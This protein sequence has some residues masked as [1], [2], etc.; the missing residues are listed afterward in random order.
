MLRLLKKSWWAIL[1]A[2]GVQSASGFTLLGLREPYQVLSL[3]Y[4]GDFSDQPK[5]FD[6]G[7]RWTIPTAYYTFDA[8][9]MSYFGSNGVWS[10]EQGIGILNALTNVSSYSP[11]L[12]EFP[13]ES[14]RVNWTAQA[15]GLFDLKS[16]T[17]EV[18]LEELG[19]GD[20]ERFAWTLRS[21][22]LPGGAQCPNYLYAV[23]QRNFDPITIAPSP[24]V[25]GNLFSYVIVDGCP[26]VDQ[27]DALE[28]PVDPTAVVA[29]AVASG[30]FMFADSFYW[31]YYYTGLTR[32]D[33]GGLRWLYRTN[34]LITSQAGGTTITFTTNNTAPQL[35]FTSNLTLF[36][37]QALTNAA[38]PLQ[39]LYPDLV[40]LST[41]NTFANV[42]T[43]NQIPYFT[44][45]PMDPVGTAPHV[46]FSYTRTLTIQPLYFHTFGN[47]YTVTNVAGG[48][49]AVPVGSLPAQNGKRIVT[50][51]TTTT[52]N[53]PYSP[54]VSGTNGTI[55][56]LTNTTFKTYATNGVVGEYFIVPTNACAVNILGLQ[57]SFTNQTTNILFN[58]TNNITNP[59][60]NNPIST[61]VF[62][63]E[64][65]M[66]NYSTNHA[67]VVAPVNCD[68][69]SVALR[70]GIEKVT[71]V[72]RDYDSLLNRFFYP[73]TNIYTLYAYTNNQIIPQRVQRIVTA[74]DILF[75]A[76]DI[77][78][79]GAPLIHTTV[80]RQVPN[81]T[82]ATNAVVAGAL[83]GP[84]TIEPSATFTF[85]KV[86]P[87]YINLGPGSEVDKQLTYIWGS[88]DGTT[89]APRVYPIGTSVY[90]L[91]NMV[92][93]NITNPSLAA[94]TVGAPYSQQM[95]G[96]GGTPP[97]TWSLR[98]DSPG[99]PVGLTLS[100]SGALTGTPTQAGVYDFVVRLTDAGARYV[101]RPYTLTINP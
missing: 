17:L 82:V 27:G 75:D 97:Y 98:S 50:L 43:T 61:N 93:I 55:S 42:W 70:Q 10:V 46:A 95:N 4:I 72:R 100:S 37:A 92:L 57:A 99:L 73:I 5:N 34:N 51:A 77:T 16:T 62:F 2:V 22:Y 78:T 19:L 64:Q 86:G 28:F 94:G 74:P 15:L 52:T 101:D 32:D 45:Y 11:G 14:I 18:L 91:E 66:V 84:G 20:P 41:S 25:N 38:G 9:F 59:D 81:F 88:Y 13:T 79:V 1:L 96:L 63:F 85:N 7:F 44:N 33:V 53:A 26:T 71:F 60:P 35:L 39:T 40:I 56:I 8:T 48:Y 21:R 36:A 83:L 30:K 67:F 68:S 3:S 65:Y 29:S 23:I 80:S 90:D 6:Q 76:D 58:A 89:N 49:Q 87:L 12:D 47:L 31:G 24:Y 69:N 54:I